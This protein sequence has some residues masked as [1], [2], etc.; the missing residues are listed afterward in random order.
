MA[1]VT[2][3]SGLDDF[4][5][6]D[7][8]SPEV[9]ANP[10]PYYD[11]LRDKPIQF[12]LEDYP[13]GTVPGQDKPYPAWVVLKYHDIIQV[14]RKPQ[15]FSSRDIMQEESDAPT[16]MLVNHDDPRHAELRKIAQ[17]A[18]KPKRVEAD[19]TPWMQGVV[20]KLLDKED[21]GEVDFMANLAPDLPALVMT[22]LIGTPEEDHV[23]LRRW[24][25]AFMVTSDFTT[26]ERNQCN[27]ELWNY[28]QDAV[29]QRY[30]DIAAGKDVPDDLMSA[31]I[32]AEADGNM[33]TKEEVIRF[34]VT[35][36]V[37]GA[38]TTGYLLGNLIDTLV[39]EPHF[40]DELKQDRSLIRPFIEESL[41]RDGP[42]Q[43]LHRVC[44]EDTEIR[45]T[46]IREGDWVAIFFAS[47]N[48]DPAIWERP[49]DFILKRPNIGRHLTFSHGVH[50][51]MGSGIARNEATQM[52]NG[53][54]DRYSAI[55][56]GS[57]PRLRQTGGLLNYGL[58]TCSIR[59]V[60]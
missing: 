18:F 22:K 23:L 1:S 24:A 15:I 20:D 55:E 2:V 31:F 21:E 28:Y 52:L 26:E 27:I 59:L 48:R 34:C 9:I 30:A 29:E 10:Y 54:L 57:A 56:P 38:E 51:C 19:I 12:G 11:A 3:A 47:G 7:L 14:C 40:F 50:H 60:R 13:P 49:N 45:G 17:I 33:L 36:V 6:K 35:L 39:E 58:E 32:Q 46:K 43:R 37:A 41:R 44:T 42:V 25:N 4:K 53:I 5:A 16:L 8:Y